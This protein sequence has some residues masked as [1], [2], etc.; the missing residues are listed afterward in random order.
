M[1]YDKQ[2]LVVFEWLDNDE[3][4]NIADLDIDKYLAE[5]KDIG[6]SSAEKLR[7]FAIY[8]EGN[9]MGESAYE[10]WQKVKKFYDAASD[11]E[12]NN[13]TV[14]ESVG[15]SVN[16]YG[17]VEK[18]PMLQ[19]E[20]FADGKEA[21]MKAIEIDSSNAQL[22][23]TLG[24]NEYDNHKGEIEQALIWFTKAIELDSNYYMAQ[25]YLGHCY[26]DKEQWEKALGAFK[27]VDKIKLSVEFPIWRLHKLNELIACCYAEIGQKEIALELCSDLL[28]IYESYNKDE[29]KD[30]LAYPDELVKVVSTELRDS[31]YIR[32]Y[33]CLE[34]FD[35]LDYYSTVLK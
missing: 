10:T 15:I 23:Y 14:L 29:W 5:V 11:Q 1:E 2:L 4:Q 31:L 34:K 30:Y 24:L 21:L 25:M 19:Q 12:P 33:N 6:I 9:Y 17:V 28:T 16:F 8:L 7:Q 32:L 18:D 20:I 13:I 27:K 3:N 35:L 22:W 26:F